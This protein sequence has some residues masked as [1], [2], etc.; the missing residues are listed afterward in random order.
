MRSL[1]LVLVVVLAGC[2]KTIVIEIGGSADGPRPADAPLQADARRVT[3]DAN[4]CPAIGST[5]VRCALVTEC[6]YGQQRCCNRIVPRQLC[7]CT[8]G[9]LMCAPLVCPP[10]CMDAGVSDGG[11]GDGGPRSDGGGL[12]A[13]AG[14]RRDASAFPDA[15]V[16]ADAAR[17]T[18]SDAARPTMTDAVGSPRG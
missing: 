13:D 4:H 15:S 7:Q 9:F 2:G 5:G 12:P 6:G 18:L 8:N 11:S 10:M 14:G 3:A 16:P 17:P 1:F